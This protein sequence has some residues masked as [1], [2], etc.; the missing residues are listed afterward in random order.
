M[1]RLEIRASTFGGNG[2]QSAVIPSRLVTARNATTWSYV[3]K[4]PITPTDLMGD[5]S[6]YD[7]VV[8]LRAVTSRD[9]MAADWFPF[10]PN[11]LALLSKRII[12]EEKCVN[13]VRYD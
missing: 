12:H 11:V 13:R 6:T 3:R 1:M 8:A 7:H 4:S 2:N 5:F 10:P 9:G